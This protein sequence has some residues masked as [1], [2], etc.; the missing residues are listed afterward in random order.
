MPYPESVINA[1]F[2]CNLKKAASVGVS[3]KE[4]NSA[5]LANSSIGKE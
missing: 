4:V 1:V 3:V 2:K 5:E